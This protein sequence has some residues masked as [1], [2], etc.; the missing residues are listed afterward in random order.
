VSGT[1]EERVAD[2]HGLVADPRVRV[3]TSAIGGNH[4]CQLLPLLDWDVIRHQPKIF[5][6]YSDMTVLNLAI[7]AR[8]GLVT[9]N[10]PHLMTDFGESPA[11][12][13]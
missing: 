3:I 11:P 9:F 1:P 10:R 12:Y 13:P 8:T 2:I 5:I 7:Y 6:G 4:S